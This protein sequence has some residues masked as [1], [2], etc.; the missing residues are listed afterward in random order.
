[1]PDTG[2][3][4]ALRLPTEL[5]V[6]IFKYCIA[7][8]P[9]CSPLLGKHSPTTLTHVC[10]YWRCVAL[11]TP[12]LWRAIAIFDS[13]EVKDRGGYRQVQVVDEPLHI[14]AASIHVA[15]RWLQLSGNLA[16]SIVVG[17]SNELATT[18]RAQSRQLRFDFLRKTL[19]P[20]HRHRIE[21]FAIRCGLLL[22]EPRLM[23]GGFNSLRFFSVETE[24]EQI[25]LLTFGPI[26]S[27]CLQTVSLRFCARNQHLSCT[28]PWLQLTKL[29]VIEVTTVAAALDILRQTPNLVWCRVVLHVSSDQRSLVVNRPVLVLPRLMVAIFEAY[30]FPATSDHR[31]YLEILPFLRLPALSRLRISQAL[32]VSDFE[33]VI[34]SLGCERLELLSVVDAW[35]VMAER[36]LPINTLFET[37]L[38]NERRGYTMDEDPWGRW[39][40]DEVTPPKSTRLGSYL[41]VEH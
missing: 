40:W 5:L 1:M 21:Y 6:L 13:V 18:D 36:R 19:L 14:V 4:S 39:G 3:S 27:P 30:A 9:A 38:L 31:V 7:P 26:S 32:L 34:S 15:E 16:L 41:R 29:D 28:L 23:H 24:N 2:L 10:R 17:A 37:L 22:H 11:S 8:Y 12:Q 25:D 33:Q 20:G 35:E